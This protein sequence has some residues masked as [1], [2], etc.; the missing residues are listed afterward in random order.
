MPAIAQMGERGIFVGAGEVVA[1]AGVGVVSTGMAVVPRI[2]VRFDWAVIGIA[3]V[4]L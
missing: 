3:T 1:G 4:R 2:W